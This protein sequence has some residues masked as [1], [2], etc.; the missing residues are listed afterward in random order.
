MTRRRHT[1]EVDVNTYVTL[2]LDDVGLDNLDDDTL[3]EYGL[4]RAAKSGAS[5]PAQALLV[6]VTDEHDAHHGAG[7]LRFCPHAVCVATRRLMYGPDTPGDG[8]A[9]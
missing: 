6:A 3:A 8:A 7:A 5:S 1:F 2:D 9:G 4:V